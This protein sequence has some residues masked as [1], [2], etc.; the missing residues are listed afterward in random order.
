MR[1]RG[2]GLSDFCRNLVQTE[3][4]SHVPTGITRLVWQTQIINTSKSQTEIS[5]QNGAVPCQSK[6][7]GILFLGFTCGL[8]EETQ[9]VWN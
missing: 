8:K 7:L 5:V 6:R 4:R 3:S 2:G 1:A 9:P